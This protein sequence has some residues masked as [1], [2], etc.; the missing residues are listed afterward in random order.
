MSL[1]STTRRCHCSAVLTLSMGFAGVP[2]CPCSSRGC[3]VGGGRSGGCFGSARWHRG[4]WG[5]RRPGECGARHRREP[6]GSGPAGHGGSA[7]PCPVLPARGVGQ[8]GRQRAPRHPA[9]P[10][11]GVPWAGGLLLMQHWHRCGSGTVLWHCTLA[12]VQPQCCAPAS[13]RPRHCNP[14]LPVSISAW[15]ERSLGIAARR[16]TLAPV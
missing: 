3:A 1:G 12:P 14:A 5:T 16:C 11:R 4:H 8:H 9:E 13:L 2:W 6:P 15:H 7:P 10:G